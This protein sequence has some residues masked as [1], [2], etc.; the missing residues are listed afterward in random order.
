MTIRIT[1]DIF[2]GRPNPSVELDD[3]ESANVLDRLMPERRLAENEPG[4]PAEPTLGYRGLVVE[5]IG[6]RREELPELF[7]VVDGD[8]FG[9]GLAH[10]ARDERVG[11][12]LI[13]ADSPLRRA[14][15]DQT[16]MERLPEEAERF[17][18]I[19]RAWPIEFPPIPFWPRC[20]RCGPIYEPGWWN[21]PSRQPFN[22][23]YNYATNYRTD[24]FA[25]PGRAAGAMYTSLSCGSV[26]PAAVADDLIDT[27]DADN[28][29]PTVGD[30][31]AMV[32]WPDADFHWY[33]K[34]RN[35]WWSHKRGG[36]PVTNVDN[37]GNYISDPRY[38]NRG[39]YI[40]FCTFMVVMHGHIKIS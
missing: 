12:Y 4:L 40:D 38:A 28:A 11:D 13:G 32:I 25:Q 29:C 22:N 2:S 35:G 18:D 33:R 16:V 20:C 14:N 37:S 7:R 9:R 3:R 17:R 26:G 31:V 27:P 24:T 39:P 5:Q 21:V 34:G 19:R 8:V 36:T 6:E 10:R 1:I 15:V 23:C 30:L